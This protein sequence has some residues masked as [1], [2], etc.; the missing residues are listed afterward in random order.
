VKTTAIY[1]LFYVDSLQQVFLPGETL[2]DRPTA[3]IESLF[4]KELRWIASRFLFGQL[5]P[6]IR[7]SASGLYNHMQH[8]IQLFVSLP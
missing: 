5:F 8:E 1:W 3:G 6:I 4:G 7:V 2:G